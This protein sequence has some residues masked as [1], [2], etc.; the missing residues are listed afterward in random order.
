MKI[1]YS[2]MDERFS[3][4][5]DTLGSQE[6]RG[7]DSHCHYKWK[8]DREDYGGG[9]ENRWT[10]KRPV[11]SN[12]TSSANELDCNPFRFLHYTITI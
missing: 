10:C 1:Q 3:R 7:F 4:Q 12:P 9:L 6:L 5:S 2:D 8:I 11:G